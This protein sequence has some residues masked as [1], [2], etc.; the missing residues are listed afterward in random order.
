MPAPDTCFS[1]LLTTCSTTLDLRCMSG[2][3]LTEGSFARMPSFAARRLHKRPSTSDSKALVGMQ[4]LLR[5]TPPMRSFS[6]RATFNPSWRRAQRSHV[7]PGTSADHDHVIK[8]GV[9]SVALNCGL[10]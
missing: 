2:R 4:P 3:K 6:T 8:L 9:S 1:R 7:A 5:Q 10:P